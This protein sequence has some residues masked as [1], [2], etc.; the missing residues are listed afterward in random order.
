M[1][2]GWTLRGTVL[3]KVSH[4]HFSFY[5]ALLLGFDEVDMYKRY[6]GLE[7]N[8]STDPKTIKAIR[9]WIFAEL[10][11]IA[12]RHH[13]KTGMRLLTIEPKKL[14]ITESTSESLEEFENR[15]GLSSGFYTQSELLEAFE[16]HH[17]NNPEI[18]SNIK[19][20]RIREKQL[21]LLAFLVGQESMQP[22][23]ND[24][25]AGWLEDSL[26][27][28]LEEVGLLQIDQLVQFINLY[29]FNWHRKIKGVGAKAANHIVKWLINDEI[30]ASLGVKLAPSVLV[31]PA[32]LRSKPSDRPPETALV[33]LEYFLV[34]SLLNSFQGKSP[35]LSKQSGVLNDK[36]AIELWLNNTKPGHTFRAYRKEAERFLLWTVLERKKSFSTLVLEDCQQYRNFLYKI[37][38]QPPSRWSEEFTIPQAEWIATRN[39][40][41][42]STF[43]RPFEGKLSAASQKYALSV[44]AAL[45]HYLIKIGYVEIN[46]FVG[47]STNTSAEGKAVTTNV[48]IQDD[49][50]AIQVFLK[51]KM[52]VAAYRRIHLI[53][54][55]VVG[56][57]L[58]MSELINLKRSNFSQAPHPNS[59][60]I[61]WQLTITGRSNKERAIPITPTL[62]EHLNEYFFLAGLGEFKDLTGSNP[63]ISAL[64]DPTKQLGHDR[65]YLVLKKIFIDVANSLSEDKT[66]QAQR[67]KQASPHSLRHI[68]AN[69]LVESG[70]QV[71][72]VKSLL[73][74]SSISAT[75]KY[76]KL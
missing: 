2:G 44:L 29:G 24:L 31:P 75:S 56:T 12:G 55:L 4:N 46:H 21:E 42:K 40:S 20:A 36:E 74:H 30:A 63:I 13:R 15:M 28:R 51:P 34:P 35:S 58:R 68:F 64:S 33:P 50:E 57:G 38:S 37:G 60:E 49:I 8:Q 70:A 11:L 47:L 69:N 5:K 61:N 19:K 23:P 16:E 43:W 76:L 48:L 10:L 66:S 9:K 59:G 72:Q 25:I 26:S 18:R 73:G 14:K 52:K 41:R 45:F 67:L 17:A 65:I 71:E 32:L 54:M 6:I 53:L 3:K 22:G 27:R 39:H 62:I 7:N 1:R